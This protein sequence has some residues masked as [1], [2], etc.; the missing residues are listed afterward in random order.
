LRRPSG[1]PISGRGGL[2]TAEERKATETVSIQPAKR[3]FNRLTAANPPEI[4]A[5]LHV[6]SLAVLL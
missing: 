1:S 4:R 3:Q 2:A 5:R 6:V